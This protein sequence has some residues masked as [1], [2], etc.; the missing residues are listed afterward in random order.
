MI[1]ADI[2]FA[3]GLRIIATDRSIA[4]HRV[5]L[6]RLDVAEQPVAGGL[7]GIVGESQQVFAFDLAF[8]QHG[9]MAAGAE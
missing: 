6:V 9:G 1:N 8:Q 5:I 4:V 7:V 2:S 3:G